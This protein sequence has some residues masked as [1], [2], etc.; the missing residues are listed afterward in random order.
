MSF[1]KVGLYMFQDTEEVGGG[2]TQYWSRVIP[3]AQGPT[4]GSGVPSLP[5]L[6]LSYEENWK[7]TVFPGRK[8]TYTR[9]HSHRGGTLRHRHTH[10]SRVYFTTFIFTETHINTCTQLPS[11]SGERVFIVLQLSC[12]HH[13]MSSDFRWWVT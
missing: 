3:S 11:D 8:K 9:K 12:I 1:L 2:S 7:R 10:D 4:S 5:Y 13:F 6:G